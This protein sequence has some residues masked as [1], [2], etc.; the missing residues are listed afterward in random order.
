MKRP[1]SDPRG[2]LLLSAASVLAL[3]AAS[4][5]LAGGT[6]ADVDYPAPDAIDRAAKGPDRNVGGFGRLFP[7]G[8]P[9]PHSDGVAEELRAH[10]SPR[11]DLRRLGAAMVQPEGEAER[12]SE[13]P[14]AYVFL[15][16]FIDHDLTLD[17]VTS[18]DELAD[19]GALENARTVDLDLDCVY[20]GGPER[21]P[22]LY[23][24]PY[25]RV[26]ALVMDGAPEE[27]RFDLLRTPDTD[28]ASANVALIGDPRNDENFVIAQIQAAFI[29]YHNRMVDRLIEAR[30]S[31][32]TAIAKAAVNEVVATEA[33]LDVA[34][35]DT[36]GAGDVDPISRAPA[37]VPEVGEVTE[38]QPG[39][40]RELARRV[41]RA[42][43]AEQGVESFADLAEPRVADILSEVEGTVRDILRSELIEG[44][45]ATRLALLEEARALTIHHYHRVIA[46]DFLPRIIGIAR[47]Q[48][49]LEN[50][51]DFYFP[52]GFVMADGR[53]LEPFI[54]IEF[55]VAAYRFGHSQVPGRIVL[56]DDGGEVAA[57][58]FGAAGALEGDVT[59]R[60]F[61]P[62]RTEQ[63]SLAVDWDLLVE[64][65]AT[66]RARPL[67][68]RAR[69]LD[70]TLSVPLGDL[71]AANIVGQGGL[72]NLASRNLSRGRT[73]LLPSGQ[74]LARVILARLEADGVLRDVY[75][76]APEAGGSGDEGGDPVPPA[77]A[78]DFVLAPDARTRTTLGLKETPLWYYILQEADEFGFSFEEAVA[79]LPGSLQ[80]VTSPEEEGGEGEPA[81]DATAMA[82][83]GA[84]GVVT[85]ATLGP[86]GGTIVGEVLLGLIDHYRETTGQGID[87][88]VRFDYA[89]LEDD[90]RPSGEGELTET[91]AMAGDQGFGRRYLLRNLLHDAGLATP[92]TTAALCTAPGTQ[93]IDA[94]RQS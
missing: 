10:A 38:T 71:A 41:L 12:T 74:D 32:A 9:V 45:A 1:T 72:S 68:Q 85:G 64:L 25:L 82:D 94:C 27:R 91:A 73:Y 35:D 4:P 83:E 93:P 58:L 2:R 8:Q 66:D 47:I 53:P 29:A 61:T 63:G 33:P 81:A 18:F 36:E 19:F 24:G 77:T 60:G 39:L 50:G 59:P 80:R 49:I 56:R 13:M 6:H 84:P 44:D 92:V 43:V 21:T 46:E 89:A 76:L 42:V 20:G 17:T 37:Q 31:K 51:R 67:V 90:A 40:A 65:D 16:Q 34:F 57:T 28:P 26:G 87:L 75:Q 15:G 70:T 79:G 23:D 14:L 48:A 69:R 30:L 3:G 52:S 22:F 7:L 54:P 78:A 62:I 86:V 88:N 5:A 11:Y 55:A